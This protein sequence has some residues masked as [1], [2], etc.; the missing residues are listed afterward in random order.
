MHQDSNGCSQFGNYASVTNQKMKRIW[1]EEHLSFDS[2]DLIET[3]MPCAAPIWR[4]HA[5]SIAIDFV[6]CIW[7]RIQSN[8]S[9]LSPIAIVIAVTTHLMCSILTC[10]SK[11]IFSTLNPS[12][13]PS[14]CD[15]SIPHSSAIGSWSSANAIE[16]FWKRGLRGDGGGGQH[17]HQ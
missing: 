8:A 7:Y 15:N 12:W 1:I 3:Y 6:N 16:S 5:T 14:N 13:N 11:L 2:V 9:G 17:A 4:W 10:F